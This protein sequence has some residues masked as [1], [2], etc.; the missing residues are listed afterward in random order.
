[1]TN[2]T[3][4]LLAQG[5]GAPPHGDAAASKLTA[6]DGDLFR[7]AL[8]DQAGAPTNVAAAAPP[9]PVAGSP[10]LAPLQN[11]IA[12]MLAAGASQSDVVTSLAAQLAASIA[13]A[14]GTPTADV[15]QQLQRVF[16]KALA[17]PETQ[18]SAGESAAGRA[19]ALA[20]R[21]VDI[22][23]TATTVAATIGQ[24]TRIA[25]NV[26]DAQRAKELPAQSTLL[27]PTAA[28]P[29]PALPALPVPLAAGSPA[30]PLIAAGLPDTP[31]AVA[32]APS[33]AG[34]PSSL[35]PQS[36]TLAAAAQSATLA[37]AQSSAPSIAAAAIA[38]L[39]M[40]AAS[41]APAAGDGRRVSIGS[42]PALSGGGDTLL[43]RI[44]TRATLADDGRQVAA[45]LRSSIPAPATLAAPA[46]SAAPATLAAPPATPAPA[47]LAAPANAAPAANAAFAANAAPAATQLATFLAA[48]ETARHA[49]SSGGDGTPT[50]QPEAAALALSGAGASA[51]FPAVA[52]FAID[53][54]SPPPPAP[55]AALPLDHSAIADQVLRG[56]LLR[57]VGE[58]SEIRLTL[59]PETLG[60]VSVKLVV[61]AGNVTAHVLAQTAEVRDA[62]AI[63]QIAR[64]GR[65]QTHRL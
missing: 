3:L 51:V 61:N 7:V 31:A 9:A 59:V 5:A 10:M 8:S 36:A 64:R 45:Q 52:P 49:G 34:V 39:P 57:N 4:D 50:A 56:A 1:M 32:G 27:I 55:A 48:F 60:D 23:A 12:T 16:A 40:S 41:S 28:L 25:G 13:Q 42:A 21:Y 29:T 44:L 63:N 54:P 30:P 6:A 53:R 14:L 33:T 65:A 11:K 37:A 26:L 35:Q 18:P 62:L 43:G 58:S 2:V 46:A 22:A 47:T 19:R 20:Q 17:P 38:A 24:Q 15:R